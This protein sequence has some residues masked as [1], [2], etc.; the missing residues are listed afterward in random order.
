MELQAANSHDFSRGVLSLSAAAYFLIIVAVMLYVSMILIGRRHWRSGWQQPGMVLHYALRV[1]SLLAVAAACVLCTSAWHDLRCDVTSE[2]LS[3]LSPQTE[4]LLAKLKL[5]RPVQIEAFLSPNVPEAYVQTRLN[6]LSVL[7]EAASPRPTAEDPTADQRHRAVQQRGRRWPRSPTAS[8][9]RGRDHRARGPR[10][11]QHLPGRGHEVRRMQK[12]VVPFIDQ[13]MPVEYEL[14]R[15]LCTVV[16]QKRE[17]DGRPHDR[18]PAVR[19]V[20]L[21]EPWCRSPN[22][23]IIDEL[24]KQYD[25]VRVDASKPITEKYDV[26]LA[27]QPSTLG[28]EDMDEFPR[29]GAQR[30]ADGDLRGPCPALVSDI[31][32]TSMPR[33]PPGRHEPHDA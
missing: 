9:P 16:Q 23:P 8:R 17:T 33:Q 4:E 24:Q 29:R 10:D 12:V 25:V 21:P 30:A 20:Q 14:V 27:V 11:G 18:R 1:L 26:L 13:G 22:W 5:D 3:S 2:H 15:S 7:R 28:P 32:P 6:L 31:T 19:L